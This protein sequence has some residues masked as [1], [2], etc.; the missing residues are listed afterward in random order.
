MSVLPIR[1]GFSTSLSKI[2]KSSDGEPTF[3]DHPSNMGVEKALPNA[4][5][6][7]RGVGVA[8]VR[9]AAATLGTTDFGMG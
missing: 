8:M 1:L 5:W 4:V 7:F 3:H 9:A 6:V 2:I